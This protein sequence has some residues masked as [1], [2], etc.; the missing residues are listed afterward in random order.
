MK[1]TAQSSL[2]YMIILAFTLAILVP[3]IY[4]FYNYS[5]DSREQ[6]IDAQVSE[7]GKKMIENSKFV[8]YSGQGS[9][10]TLDVDMPIGVKKIYVV[11]K[12]ELVFELELRTGDS[13]MVFFSSL[14]D[15]YTNDPAECQT[16][17]GSENE[18][19]IS[20]GSLSG[21]M[22]IRLDA[23]QNNKVFISKI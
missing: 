18:C 19:Y 10:I 20:R 6:I 9:R 5:T 16:E 14:V 17:A 11:G 3:S 2:E 7:I 4:L 22:K 12:R 15:M 23:D 13:Q 21:K 1:R 8:H